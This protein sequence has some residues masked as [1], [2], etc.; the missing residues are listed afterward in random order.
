MKHKA[1]IVTVAVIAIIVGAVL[2]K[3]QEMLDRAS[4]TLA[5]DLSQALGSKITIGK[6]EVTSFNTLTI[7]DVAVYDKKTERLLTSPKMVI[8]YS[9]PALLR[10]IPVV[11]AISQI[12]AIKPTVVLRQDNSGNWNYADLV[13]TKDE[14]Q[15]EFAGKV[16]IEDGSLLVGMNDQE[17]QFDAV[18]GM[19]D[20]ADHPAAQIKLTGLRQGAKLKAE[21]RVDSKRQTTLTLDAAELTLNDYQSLYPE[22][23]SIHI[24][25][26]KL[27]QVTFT[28]QKSQDEVKVAGEARLDSVAADIDN[29]SVQD[30]Q[31]LITF[32]NTDISFFDT[33]AKVY[34]QPVKVRG[35][36]ALDSAVPALDLDVSSPGF[37]LSALETDLPVQGTVSGQ[38]KVLGLAN[39][40][41]IDGQF[42][43]PQG[44][45][46]GYQVTDAK[47]KL[48]LADRQLFFTDVQAGMLGGLISAQG[49]LD[50]NTNGYT[51]A[52]EGKNTN[53]SLIREAAPYIAGTGNFA[54]D[55]SGQGPIENASIKGTVAMENGA[56]QGVLFEKLHA[57]FWQKDGRLTID[58]LNVSAGGGAAA[59]SGWALTDGSSIN[60]NVAA[61][62]LSPAIIAKLQDELPISGQFD[63]DGQINGSFKQPEV[64]GQF[65]ALNGE[66]FNQPF[67]KAEGTIYLRGTE[68]TLEDVKLLDGVTRH[69]VQGKI[70]LAGEQEITLSVVSQKARAEN[71]VKLFSADERLTGNVDNE[72]QLYGP[73]K[74][75]NAKGHIV[76]TEGSFRGQLVAKGEGFYERQNGKIIL[77]DFM[78]NSLNTDV[79]A[80]GQIDE[81]QMLN[82]DVAAHNVD[83]AKLQ[84]E[85]PYPLAGKADF[86]GKV[87]GTMQAPEFTGELSAQQ[88]WFNGKKVQAVA[89]LAH[90][91]GDELEIS[92]LDFSQENGKFHFSGGIN[93]ASREIFGQLDVE[94]AE[95][96]FL[97]AAFN[98]P[99][100]DLSGC[101]NGQLK[102]NG[103]T[104]QPNVWLS[105]Q[106]TQGQ[107]K[108]YALENIE[109]DAQLV[110]HVV[111]INKFT[112][113]QGKGILAASGTAD[114]QGPLNL[115]IGGRDIDAGLLSAWFN[116]KLEAKGQLSFTAQVTGTA[117]KPHTAVS[118]DIAGGGVSNATFDSLYGLF[119]IDKS[120]LHVNQLLL[121]KGPYRASAYGT[122]PLAPFSESGRADTG[123][124]D[125]INLVVKLDEADLSILPLL[126]KDVAWAVG[127]TQGGITIGGTLKQPLMQGQFRVNNGTIKLAYLNEPIK[128]VGV[129][130]QL[131][132]D[133]IDVKTIEGSMGKGGFRLF[134]TTELKGLTLKNYGL[135]LEMN[136]MGISSKYFKGPVNGKLTLA[137][138]K[139]RPML[140]GNLTFDEDLV[141]IPALPAMSQTDFDVDLNV[142][143]V[144]GR[145][146]HFYNSL[147]YDFY[148]AG[149]VN[150]A[151][152]TKNPTA[153]GHIR[154]V[155]GTVNYLRTPFKINEGSM[156][157]A[158]FTTLEPVIKLKAQAKL[159]QT[160]VDLSVNGPFSAL[161]LQLKSDPPMRQ[162]EILSLLTL[163]SHFFEN[164][165]NGAASSSGLGREEAMSLLDAGLQMTFVS[166]VEGA[167]RNTFGLDEFQLK[168]DFF[169]VDATTNVNRQQ[170][171]GYSVEIGKYIND[172][173]MLTHLIGLDHYEYKTAFRYD[174]SRHMS[175]TGSI[176]YR[177]NKYIGIETRFRFK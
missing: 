131:N 90:F 49:M 136:K 2:L 81:N 177:S 45:I 143:V 13:Q 116:S 91:I 5:Q 101:L 83:L 89:G 160:V 120:T 69:L 127:Q 70:S 149:R 86:R 154:A 75:F 60:M 65:M 48:H 176:D 63:F 174:F 19:V 162:S 94:N 130:I 4:Q 56:V 115:E 50:L 3:G 38:A 54:V 122:V 156:E 72:I 121:S 152:S 71:L 137:E 15:S 153:F 37:D 43:L 173:L 155:R 46:E 142:D 40:P 58:Y 10:G 12:T 98:V 151:G 126:T 108:K 23:S 47:A 9:I 30:I 111:T 97:L 123:E 106:L 133:K 17:W 26:G 161:D 79:L 167:F 114:L 74:N 24:L 39:N 16:S 85:L 25:D 35:K 1:I 41:V 27:R 18:N 76:L 22:N 87:T 105:G 100:Q 57:G 171:E 124:E 135:T 139:G 14:S 78:V 159:E 166:E 31:G 32:T 88:L 93:I 55:I 125:Q 11:E 52:C 99:S 8:N 51:V 96:E 36:V 6:V 157:F 117:E 145:K 67:Q 82:L 172:R 104:N 110:N 109:I 113:Q 92:Q 68:L 146:V 144:V 103:T 28:L 61:Q 84:V 141:N 118:M 44:E 42:S 170:Q 147:L 53:T 175:I 169:D 59:L 62:G 158:K 66:L 7:D 64:S 134:G 148:A 164:Q 21:G 20:F 102:L 138:Q 129:D 132:N 95:L 107:I 165:R 29:V 34:Q 33:A 80:S 119:V 112:A 73:I 140:E 168:R 77:K 163:R 150:F 128:N